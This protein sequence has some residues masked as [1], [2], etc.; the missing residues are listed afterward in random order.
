METE[1]E[2]VVGDARS[3]DGLA[4]ASV[5]LVVTSPP[6]P[7]IEMWDGAFARM[8]P[9][10]GA[11]LDAGDAW[12]AFELMHAE[13]DAV[14]DEVAR[15]LVR[16]G[17][18][19]VNVGD[20]TRRLDGEFARFPNHARVLSALSDRGLTPLPGVLWRKPTNA[21]TKFMGSG[22]LPPNAYVT[23]EHEHVLVLRKGEPRSFPPGDDERYESAYFWEERNDWFSDV[24]TDV[25][26]ERQAIPG[27]GPR[28]RAGAFPFE[29]PFRLINMYSVYGDTVCDPFWGTGTTT[30]AAMVAAR[31]SVGYEVEPELLEGFDDRTSPLPD[32]SRAVQ[33]DR[34]RAHLAFVEERAG[35]GEAPGHVAERYGFPVVTRQ[36][37]RIALYGVEELDAR[38][39]EPGAGGRRYVA[40]H[41]PVDL[42]PA[43]G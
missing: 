1:H 41:A 30:I 4:D 29:V 33:R 42:P 32:V 18:A 12:G 31:N 27:D 40:T 24:W 38:V 22:T 7:M 28:D 35:D 5:E 8:N 21:A 39:D 16:G 10:V 36:E 17:I 3:M 13:L 20:A 14:W 2:V 23:Q 15:V 37:V 34:L 25:A 43:G 9:E 19:C 26:G 11:R 6:Y